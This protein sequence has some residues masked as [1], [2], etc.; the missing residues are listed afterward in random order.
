M[1]FISIADSKINKKGDIV[2]TV[3]NIGD[4]K[5]GTSSNGDWRK[6]NIT[7]LDASCSESMTAWNDDIE[8]F[9]LH[10]KY[11]LTGIYWKEHDGKLY[12]NFGKYS[13]TKDL[14]IS[15]EPNQTTIVLA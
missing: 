10:H 1:E 3:T 7:I 9:Q 11:E 12:L 6:K 14:G 13:K 4:L 15:T 8:K 5:A 2:V